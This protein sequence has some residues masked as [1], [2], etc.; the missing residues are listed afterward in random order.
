M[1]NG[2]SQTVDLG[3]VAALIGEGALGDDLAAVE[4]GIDPMD[5]DAIDLDTVGV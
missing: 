3:R 5:G 4:V 1:F 2:L